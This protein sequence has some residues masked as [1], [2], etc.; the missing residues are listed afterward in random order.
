MGGNSITKGENITGSFA[1]ENIMTKITPNEWNLISIPS[2]LVTTSQQ[3]FLTGTVQ[4]IWGYE[5]GTWVKSPRIIEAGKGYW[6]KG[7]NVTNSADRNFSKT[8]ATGY[9]AKTVDAT[10]VI[11]NNSS[12]EWRLLGIPD[13]NLSWVDAYSQVQDNCHTVSIYAY[14]PSVNPET[15]DSQTAGWNLDDHIPALSGI[16]VKQE[17]C[18]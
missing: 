2:G 8:Q 1:T 6:V 7:L 11:K 14:R 12:T 5:N 15:N 17:N 3:M 18:Q 13:T 10:T 16:W 4:T 9:G